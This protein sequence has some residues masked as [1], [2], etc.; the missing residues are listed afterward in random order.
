MYSNKRKCYLPKEYRAVAGYQY[1][2]DVH[3]AR[4]DLIELYQVKRRLSQSVRSF[5]EK[6][7]AIIR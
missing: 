1:P 4:S 3:E 7:R 2:S 5:C 6:P